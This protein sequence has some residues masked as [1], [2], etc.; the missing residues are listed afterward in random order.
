MTTAREPPQHFRGLTRSQSD[1]RRS[2]TWRPVLTGVGS[3][4]ALS[5]Q[6]RVE[7][8]IGGVGRGKWG[9]S[10]VCDKSK[11]EEKCQD[12]CDTTGQC[13][14]QPKANTPKNGFKRPLQHAVCARASR[15]KP[16]RSTLGHVRKQHVVRSDDPS[17]RRRPRSSA[18][19]KCVGDP[20]APCTHAY[21]R[22]WEGG[23]HQKVTAHSATQTEMSFIMTERLVLS[24]SKT[25]FNYAARHNA[26][27][28][29]IFCNMFLI[30]YVCAGH[31]RHRSV[32][33]P[34]AT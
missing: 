30:I 15:L 29:K 8:S 4:A 34:R 14:A 24:R 1:S 6:Q 18:A 20:S 33:K 3:P 22:E 7:D 19:R 12:F 25:F 27:M 5:I 32:R 31:W 28:D 13:A 16:A 26:G 10:A 2:T 23:A 11:E 21:S 17:H 9:E